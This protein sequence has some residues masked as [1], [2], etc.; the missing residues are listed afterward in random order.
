MGYT[1]QF[2][3]EFKPAPGYKAPPSC[4]HKVKPGHKYC[5]ECGVPIGTIDLEI[6]VA[7]E[8]NGNEEMGYCLE[9]GKGRVG[10]STGGDGRWYEHEKDM[11]EI[12]SRYPHIFF[13]LTGEGEESGDLW[14][15]YFLNGKCQVAKAAI[16]IAPFDPEK[17]V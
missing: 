9:V 12:S 4:K 10:H 16:V 2:T 13:T 3:L 5:P 11:R 8:I 7:C 14:K 6:I 15:K 17:L 1:T